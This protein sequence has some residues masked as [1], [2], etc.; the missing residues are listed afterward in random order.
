MRNCIASVSGYPG[1]ASER[2]Q[3]SLGKKAS[4]DRQKITAGE[5]RAGPW[6][7]G[8]LLALYHTWCIHRRI[9]WATESCR[10]IRGAVYKLFVGQLIPSADLRFVDEPPGYCY[11][12]IPST[13]RS[14]SSF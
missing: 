9:V 2:S 13:S 14:K 12:C 3:E 1:K 8:I 7:L 4:I 6:S 11:R 5:T 10:F